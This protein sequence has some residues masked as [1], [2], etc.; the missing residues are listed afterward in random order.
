MDPE[1]STSDIG[2]SLTKMNFL[3]SYK[4]TGVQ[5][6]ELVNLQ[7]AREARLIIHSSLSLNSIGVTF[8][9]P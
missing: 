4:A 8:I 3:S 1:L 5:R 6:V 2:C 9:V 7:E